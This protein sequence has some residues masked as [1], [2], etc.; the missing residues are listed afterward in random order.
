MIVGDFNDQFGMVQNEWGVDS[1]ALDSRVGGALPGRQHKTAELIREWLPKHDICVATTFHKVGFTYMNGPRRSKIY[2]VLVPRGGLTR[3]FYVRADYNAMRDL[4]L[5]ARVDLYDHAPLTGQVDVSV[6]HP[7]RPPR[8]SRICGNSVMDA[9]LSGAKRDVYVRELNCELS[10]LGSKWKSSMQAPSTCTAWGLLSSAI[11]RAAGKVFPRVGPSEDPVEAAFVAKRLLLLQDRA[12][13]RR[14][15]AAE[16]D[17]EG[18]QLELVMTNRRLRLL[19]RD[20]RDH[21]QRV[22]LDE[23]WHAW[24]QRR[25]HEIHRLRGLLAGTGRAPRRRHLWAASRHAATKDEWCR[26]LC[27]PGR[28]GGVSCAQCAAHRG[29]G[30]RALR[31]GGRVV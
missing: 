20:Q 13:L 8:A 6:A 24:R 3:V 11:L 10:S 4:Q 31:R 18:V 27:A 21:R 26:L 23:L 15:A 19:R 2:H 25:H 30:G 1:A 28:D 16:D 29:R 12:A 22:Q 9:L 17:I 5:V 7:Q 14:R